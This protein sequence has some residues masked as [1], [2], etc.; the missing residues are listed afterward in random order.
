[1]K[2]TKGVIS[3]PKSTRARGWCHSKHTIQ[4]HK[5]QK[6][7]YRIVFTLCVQSQSLSH[8]SFQK[9]QWVIVL[10]MNYN[11]FKKKQPE[12]PR[13]V[14]WL[15]MWQYSS[16]RW[17]NNILVSGLKFNRVSA[18]ACTLYRRLPDTIRPLKPVCVCV[19]DYTLPIVSTQQ[20]SGSNLSCI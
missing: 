4:L 8:F 3:P 2:A 16:L 15:L 7:S 20:L 19:P 11:M 5:G 9:C 18:N 12:R 10:I 13:P 17:R 1:M 6:E 14:S